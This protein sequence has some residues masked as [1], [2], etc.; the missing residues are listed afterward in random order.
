[1][2]I[3]ALVAGVSYTYKL[4]MATQQSQ[5]LV[6]QLADSAKR[7]SGIAVYLQDSELA[8]EIVISLTSNDLIENALIISLD[9][10]LRIGSKSKENTVHSSRI[11]LTNPFM[12]DEPLGYLEVFPNNKFI[13]SQASSS[14]L[15]TAFLLLGL[16]LFTSIIVGLFIRTKLTLPLRTLADEFLKVDVSSPNKLYEVDIGYT[17]KDEIGLL[18]K[19][20]NSLIS[21]LQAQFMS[22]Y[23]LRK[24][25]EEVQKRFRLLFEQSTAG[26]GLLDKNGIVTIANPALNQLLGEQTVGK[27]LSNYFETP[28]HLDHHITSINDDDT[29]S[30]VGIDLINYIAGRKRHLHCLL[31][32]IRESR[33]EVRDNSE[34]LIEVMIYDVTSRREQESRTRYEAD[35]DSLTGLLN[36]RAGSLKLA[37]KLAEHYKKPVLYFT[38]LMIDLD[39]FKPIN[40]T[41]GHDV[42]DVVLQK[43]SERLSEISAAHDSVCIRWG[44]DE[45][46]VSVSM[47]DLLQVD[48]YVN[49]LL[50]AIKQDIVIDNYL[51]V[52]VG[53]S[54][55]ALT[56]FDAA[57]PII[58]I[59]DIIKGADAL[60]YQIKQ[61]GKDNYVLKSL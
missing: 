58:L 35:H 60:M 55:G 33:R 42:G 52:S 50:N 24:T 41:Y 59:D 45:F 19:K 61:G 43:V 38:L 25:T 18:I 13:K 36:R 47:S 12:V 7:T 8:S 2:L 1:M 32:T 57:D 3:S 23:E 44:G 15:Q 30:Q 48:R 27:L 11:L 51:T 6:K 16:S 37:E 28:D 14:S 39:K 10:V 29:D 46:L 4:E 31:S 40:D 56:L 54:I 26:I 22:E 5:L 17:S 53:S 9:G 20:I 49:S 34:H 21:A